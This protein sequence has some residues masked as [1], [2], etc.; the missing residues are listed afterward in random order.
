MKRMSGKN[1]LDT[2][3]LIYAFARDDARAAALMA[4][5]AEL[6]TTMPKLEAAAN[7]H[8]DAADSLLQEKRRQSS[9]V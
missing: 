5:V 3:I 2:N 6:K 4:E 9:Q 8:I 1:F 7:R